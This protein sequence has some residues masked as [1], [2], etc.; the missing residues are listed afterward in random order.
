MDMAGIKHTVQVIGFNSLTEVAPA[1]EVQ[2]LTKH[3][4]NTKQG[5]GKAFNREQGKVMVMLGMT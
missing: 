4:P 3:F 2:N 1:P 5:A